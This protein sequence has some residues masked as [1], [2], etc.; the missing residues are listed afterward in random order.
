MQYF[1]SSVA[2]HIL[3][4]YPDNTN[5]ICVVTPNRRSGLFFRKH[6]SKLTTGPIWAPE[7]ISFEDFLSRLTGLNIC[8]H[9]TLVIEFYKT[10]KAVQKEKPEPLEHFLKWAPTLLKDFNDIDAGIAN[11][12]EFFSYLRDLKDIEAWNPEG[13]GLTDFQK[14]YLAFFQIMQDYY[15]NLTEQLLSRNIA[16][17]GLAIRYAADNLEKLTENFPWKKIIFAGFNAMPKGEELI[18][19]KLVKGGFAEVL[20]DAD[21]YYLNN[22]DHEAGSYLR[23]YKENW[24]L[25]EFNFI[26]DYYKNIPKK[27]HVAGIPKN[28]NQAKFAG[29][30]LKKFTS[31]EVGEETAVVLA[32]ESLLMPVLNSLP[33]NVTSL[34][35]TMGFPLKKTGLYG[36]F[37]AVFR[38]H[39]NS[40]KFGLEENKPR[41][42]HKDI[43]RVFNHIGVN[44]LLDKTE[45][46]SLKEYVTN[47]IK[48]NRILHSIKTISEIKN[49]DK[50][51]QNMPLLFFDSWQDPKIAIKS[52]LAVCDMM[53]TAILKIE[54][55]EEIERIKKIERIEKIEKIDVVDEQAL[56]NIKSILRRLE[57]FINESNY[58]QNI[59]TLFTLFQSLVSESKLSFTGEPLKGLQVI[60]MLETRNLDFK[61]L[62]ILS[63]NED[64]LPAPSK[65]V[66]FIHFDVRLKFGLHIY[67]DSDALYAYH[68]YRLLQ[69]AENVYLIYN[70]QPDSMG[71]S[72][73]SRFITQIEHELS[74][75]NPNIS[76]THNIISIPIST[77]T[78]VKPIDIKKTDEIIS[79]L[80]TQNEK[81]FSP[82]ALSKYINCPLQF[83]FSYI[84][85]IQ[86]TEEVE[87]T[88]EANTLG[89]V[90]HEVLKE[91]YSEF[92]G[93]IV[94]P[95]DID[96]M[97]PKIEKTTSEKFKKLYKGGNIS[98]GKN[99]LIRRM[100]ER[101]TKN[102]LE[103]EIKSL[104]KSGNQI[105]TI[106][107]L[108]EK[109]DK[110]LNV[111]IND[112]N[113]NFHFKGTIDR[114][115]RINGDLRIIDY[116]TG[117]VDKKNLTIKEIE[118]VFKDPLLNKSFQLMMY[119]YIYNHAQSAN[120]VIPGIFSLRKFSSGLF[121]LNFSDKKTVDADTL[122]QFE[123]G[124]ES[125][126]L[127]IFDDEVMFS[128]TPD[129]DNCKFCPFKVIC[130]RL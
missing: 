69:R 93:K 63:V 53:E 34:N 81:G 13:T 40:E 33:D 4:N 78:G 106:I 124:L 18:I 64:I 8:D 108:E 22:K 98:T 84:A 91:L 11:P 14:D 42:Y 77:K 104:G 82:S 39:I 71:S 128:Q 37:E 112:K 83:Y 96:A 111:K 55:I 97:V 80:Y 30:I 16:Y 45:G 121:T 99:L 54:K 72:E 90:V 103:Q 51:I 31:N 61:N 7:I 62:I 44:L 70:T 113:Y 24:G 25:K 10:Y 86:E 41:F 66:S 118:D 65:K 50:I 2:E 87:E 114:I 28:V 17:Q 1:L 95:E 52:L 107:A 26:G 57:V 67:S 43:N 94:K 76:I 27:I 116:K 89:N 49:G 105:L 60:G 59:K 23:K 15:T 109:F 47:I 119:S 5:E 73:K 110:T 9:I 29:N 127:E 35:V 38:M 19:K 101:F 32:N 126:M 74:D 56:N 79:K 21:N 6:L 48:S 120:E 3:K 88:I 129:E 123:K 130:N 58:I 36:F 46:I 92:V 102:F 117:N 122:N 12:K 125:L 100:A 68:F 115:D 85:E 20:W 75:Y